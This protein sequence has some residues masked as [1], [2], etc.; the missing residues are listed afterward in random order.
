MKDSGNSD[1]RSSPQNCCVLNVTLLDEFRKPFWCV[2]TPVCARPLES[3]V[4][5]DR[6]GQ[7]FLIHH[8]DSDGQ[9]RVELVR[10]EE[11]QQQQVF[12][13]GLVVSVPVDKVNQHFGR[14]Y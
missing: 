1:T 4:C 7:R 13:V 2:S 11:Q 12:L 9:V 10:A 8:R 14:D 5:Y 3:C 6:G